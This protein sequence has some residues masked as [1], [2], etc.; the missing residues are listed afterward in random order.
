MTVTA[1]YGN[2]NVSADRCAYALAGPG[3]KKITIIKR[4]LYTQNFRDGSLASP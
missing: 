3:E 2:D 1:P 4:D